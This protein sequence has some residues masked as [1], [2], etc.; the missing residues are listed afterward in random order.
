MTTFRPKLWTAS[1]A[2]LLAAAACG[3]EGGEAG[4]AGEAG[5][6]AAVGEGGE[7]GAE[8]GAGTG[9]AGAQSA[10]TSVPAESHVALRLA[11]LNGFLLAALKLTGDPSAA[12]ALVG[13]GMAEV[14]DAQ[15]G[16]FQSAGLDPLP[17]RKAAETGA[18][19]DIG[20]AMDAIGNA[21]FRA[22][23]DSAAVVKGLVSITA[24]LYRGVIAEGSIDAIEY[25]HAYG[26]ALA[27]QAAASNST[28]SKVVAAKGEIDKLVAM[29]PAATAPAQPTPV[30]QVSAQASR[31]ELALS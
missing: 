30:A 10:Y 11:H 15:P 26:A 28:D 31:I 19:A 16:A 2:V 24:G 12:S 3:G 29:F 17:L 9:E 18:E 6:A 13:Q 4:E 5:P 25:Q 1:I 23:G 20:A 7:G 27:A 22:K 21:Q 8:G 14:Y